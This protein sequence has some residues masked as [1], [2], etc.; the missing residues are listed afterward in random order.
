MLIPLLVL[1]TLGT[2]GVLTVFGYLGTN[3]IGGKT[4]QLTTKYFVLDHKSRF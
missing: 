2:I 1:Y 4:T 3:S